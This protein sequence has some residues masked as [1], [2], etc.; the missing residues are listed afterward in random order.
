MR[1]L[2]TC[3]MNM[4][5]HSAY[6]GLGSNLGD[7]LATLRQA[8]LALQAT[9]GIR[10]I[11]T[12][13]LYQTA[14]VGGPPDQ[15]DYLN[16]ALEIATTL[17][18]LELLQLCQSIEATFGRQRNVHWGARTLDIDLLLFA[19]RLIDSSELQLP[20]PRLTERGFVLQ[21]LC[22][23]APELQHPQQKQTLASLLAK[24]SPLQGVHHLDEVW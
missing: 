8:R 19:D 22:D 15:S 12:S 5:E 14:P 18:P 9:T 23:L 4:I 3:E 24:I 17:E 2:K 7:R 21:P 20:H 16:G 6:L 10:V 1:R 11:A 13:S